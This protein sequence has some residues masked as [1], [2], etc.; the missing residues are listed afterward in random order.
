MASPQAVGACGTGNASVESLSKILSFKDKNVISF[1]FRSYLNLPC[2]HV[3][4]IK[5]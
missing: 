4:G 5:Q 2:L 3:P 1:S